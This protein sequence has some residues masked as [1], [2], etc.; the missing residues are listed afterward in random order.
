MYELLKRYIYA[1]GSDE[2]TAIVD[3]GT[4]LVF[5]IGN[6]RRTHARPTHARTHHHY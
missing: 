2:V 1:N 5:G 6:A 4:S 3:G